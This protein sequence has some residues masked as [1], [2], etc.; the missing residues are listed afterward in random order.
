MIP[1][2]G[3]TEMSVIKAIK[4]CK[5]VFLEVDMPST[6]VYV[7]VSKKDLLTQIQANIGFNAAELVIITRYGNSALYLTTYKGS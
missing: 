2:E 4:E 5:E 1:S 7:K 6:C 3:D